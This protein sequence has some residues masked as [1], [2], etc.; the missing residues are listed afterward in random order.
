MKI[1]FLLT[2]ILLFAGT[3]RPCLAQFTLTGQS[4][5]FLVPEARVI[6]DEKI[7]F[8]SSFHPYSEAFILYGNNRE[9]TNELYNYVT[10]GFLPFMELTFNL[11]KIFDA[12]LKYGVGDRSSSLR[13]LLKKETKKFPSILLGVNLPVSSNNYIDSN[14]LTAT[15]ELSIGGKSLIIS[16]GFGMPW[17]L[18]TPLHDG[19]D[20]ITFIRKESNYQVGLF[21]SSRLSLSEHFLVSFE[22]DGSNLNSG[23]MAN[24]FGDKCFLKFYTFNFQTVGFGVSYNG[25]VK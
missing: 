25:V 4:G 1:G 20:Y 6:G 8:G 12:P 21:A 23:V 9:G 7:A 10:L 24:F 17:V 5:N 16:G 11:T 2:S 14:F 13:F 18:R 19:F 3:M 15:K 22:Y